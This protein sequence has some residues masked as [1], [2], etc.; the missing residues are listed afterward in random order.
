MLTVNILI[1]LLFLATLAVMALFPSLQSDPK[2]V[3]VRAHD[4]YAQKRIHR[5]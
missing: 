1:A 5:H 3:R 4:K 2:P